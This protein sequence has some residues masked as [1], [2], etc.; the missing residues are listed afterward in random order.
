MP[1][2]I[3]SLRISIGDNFTPLIFYGRMVFAAHGGSPSDMTGRRA[4]GIQ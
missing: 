3:S 1:P 2:D 4:K